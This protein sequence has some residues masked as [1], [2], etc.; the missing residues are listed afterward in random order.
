M[1][2]ENTNLL[3]QSRATARPAFERVAE[4][5]Q[6]DASLLAYLFGECLGEILVEATTTGSC[7]LRGL[8]KFRLTTLAALA[9]A[10]HSPLP[11]DAAESSLMLFDRTKNPVK[12]TAFA[13]LRLQSR[14]NK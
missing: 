3:K 7:T 11:P 13:A 10:N 1:S 9:E 8:G 6:V 12:N 5:L 4:R 2:S 14:L